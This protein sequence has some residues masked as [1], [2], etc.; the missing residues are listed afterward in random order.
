MI[1]KKNIP[2]FIIVGAMKA[3]TSS[4]SRYMNSHP[5]IYIP[6]EE[7]HFFNDDK[8][9]SKG[10]KEYLKSF[11]LENNDTVN[12]IGEKTPTYSN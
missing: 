7:I 9:Y 12:V 4:L 1:P 3:G 8:K 11:N 10:I 2:N 5:E 6:E